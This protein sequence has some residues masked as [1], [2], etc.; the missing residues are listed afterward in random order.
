KRPATMAIGIVY[1]GIF[2]SIGLALVLLLPRLGEQVTEFAKE[3]P[4]YIE[5][6]RGRGQSFANLYQ[7]YQLPPS[8]REAINDSVTR[9]IESSGEYITGELTSVIRLVVYLPWLVL[10]P[11][12]AFFL[13]KDADAFRHAALQ[14]LPKGRLR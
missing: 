5:T 8:V 1:L 7:H 11:I 10:I 2:G 9:G 12:F 14:I 6:I 13:L 3:A 4:T